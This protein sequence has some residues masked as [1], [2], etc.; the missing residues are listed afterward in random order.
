MF[1]VVAAAILLA[2]CGN[3]GVTGAGPAQRETRDVDAFTRVEVGNGIGLTLHVGGSQA[4]ELVAQ[5]NI[6]GLITTTVEDGVLRISATDSFTTSTGVT[7]IA[8]V[9]ALKGLSAS[10][11]SQAQIDGLTGDALDIDLT[12]GARL[13]ATGQATDV[14][15]SASAG[16]AAD[17]GAL[18]ADTMDVD[19]S[20]GATVALNVSDRLTGSASGGAVAT[21]AGL[22]SVEVETSGGARV[23]EN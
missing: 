12:G 5:E 22:A 10:G 13:M 19:L 8:T 7:V 20:G 1:A 15:L 3:G 23:T 14:T 18:A 4:V 2:A 11:G 6:L 9:Q 16:A 17:L 21:V